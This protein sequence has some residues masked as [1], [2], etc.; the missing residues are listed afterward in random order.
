MEIKTAP[1]KQNQENDM[2]RRDFLSA[3]ATGLAAFVFGSSI[4]GSSRAEMAKSIATATPSTAAPAAD[5]LQGVSAG[6]AHVIEQFLSDPRV[7]P[8]MKE[9]FKGPEIQTHLDRAAQVFS[10][11]RADGAKQI[12][13]R[14]VDERFGAET[15]QVVAALLQRQ[16]IDAFNGLAKNYQ[17]IVTADFQRALN[18]GEFKMRPGT[19]FK[20]ELADIVPS[21]AKHLM[22]DGALNVTIDGDWGKSS[23]LLREG[24]QE[25]LL[26]TKWFE[27][28]KLTNRPMQ[29]YPHQTL[30][31]RQSLAAA[32]WF[33]P[34]LA[35]LQISAAGGHPADVATEYYQ[36][37]N[38]GK[39]A[40]GFGEERSV[41][42]KFAARMSPD[43]RPLPGF[44]TSVT[45]LK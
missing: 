17:E 1:H 10:E 41:G 30:I 40:A 19:E 5:L 3:A 12:N 34:E 38:D 37:Q 6:R 43:G 45:D 13:L 26:R 18:A 33:S 35:A 16:M 23:S 11:V 4:E 29:D 24:V 14:E 25:L 2:G 22:K 9:I 28:A 36:L 20:F 31:G 39:E 21:V 27:Y 32:R 8:G 44:V 15:T 42:R 7:S